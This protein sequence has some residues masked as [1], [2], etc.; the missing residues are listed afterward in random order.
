[1]GINTDVDTIR[2][3]AEG[4]QKATGMVSGLTDQGRGRKDERGKSTKA[5]TGLTQA[6]KKT[7]TGMK[8]TGTATQRAGQK[9]RQ[10]SKDVTAAKVGFLGLND[11][12]DKTI[13]KVLLWSVST[14]VIFGTIRAFRAL[15]GVITEHDTQMTA[16]RKV[17][18]GAESD[19]AGIKIQVIDT[20]RAMPTPTS[21]AI[22]ACSVATRTGTVG[23]EMADV[24]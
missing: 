5:F 19:I 9:T 16:L 13:R 15:F 14:S 23:G 4:L 2:L 7:A 3:R 10:L 12:L 20:A 18:S 22:Q 8:E 1:M 21:R 6:A 17:Y 11:T 24:T